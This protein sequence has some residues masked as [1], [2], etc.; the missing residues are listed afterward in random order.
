MATHPLEEVCQVPKSLE[1]NPF[2]LLVEDT[3]SVQFLLKDNYRL[4]KVQTGTSLS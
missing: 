4:S 2:T 3:V 1:V